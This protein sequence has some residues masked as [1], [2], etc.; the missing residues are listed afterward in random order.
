MRTKE[1]IIKSLPDLGDTESIFRR[2]VV[3]LLADI[4]DKM[5]PPVYLHKRKDEATG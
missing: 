3:E 1:E 4:R 5:N 2:A